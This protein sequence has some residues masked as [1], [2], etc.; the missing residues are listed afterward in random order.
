MLGIAFIIARL[1]RAAVEVRRWTAVCSASA[2]GGAERSRARIELS[3]LGDA[4]H[5]DDP[6]WKH[7][8]APAS[9]REL[10]KLHGR[11]TCGLACLTAWSES[12]LI[13]GPR[14]EIP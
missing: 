3:R 1:K 10:L 5:P 13:C 4:K 7:E 6:D 12:L 8:S 14:K 9:K 11:R 2:A